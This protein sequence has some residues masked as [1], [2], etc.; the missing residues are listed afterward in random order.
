MFTKLISAVV[1]F[2]GFGKLE[3]GISPFSQS[4]NKDFTN[5]LVS[6]VSMSPTIIKYALLGL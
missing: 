3:T 4:A 1:T 6:L 5:S 2:F